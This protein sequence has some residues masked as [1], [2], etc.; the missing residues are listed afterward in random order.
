[1]KN[2]LPLDMPDIPRNIF[3]LKLGFIY[4]PDNQSIVEGLIPDFLKASILKAILE[5]SAG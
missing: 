4:Q 5:T 1:M 3:I 2:L